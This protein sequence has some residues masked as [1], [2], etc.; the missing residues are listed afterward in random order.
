MTRSEQPRN[1]LSAPPRPVLVQPRLDDKPWGSR[2]LADFGFVLPPNQLI[3]EAL[4]TAPDAI[5][6]T[7][8]YDGLTLGE[9][10]SAAPEAWCGALGLAATAGW[11]GFPLLAKIID[12][13][14]TLSLQVHPD[15]ALAALHQLGTGKTEAWHILDARP[16]AVLYAGLIPGVDRAAFEAA[17]Q[18]ADGSAAKWLQRFVAQPGTTVVIPA[19]TV[20]AIGEGVLIYEIQQPSNVTFRLDDWGRRDAQGR[21]RDL[22][23]EIGFSAINQASRPEAI[24]PLPL[25]RDDHTSQLLAATRYFALEQVTLAA[26]EHGTLPAVHS[27]QVVTALRGEASVQWHDGALALDSGTTAILP[28]ALPCQLAAVASS[29]VLRGWVPDLPHDVIAPARAAGASAAALD[30]FGLG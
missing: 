11:P 27:P 26:G 28:A 29:V 20:H 8:P 23:H 7:P 21:S 14:D 2:R 16:G 19:G 12:A 6:R 5:V 30:R 4:L 1:G 25:R 15:D 9:L 24:A 3:G 22:H 13:T 18:R 10:T 17:C